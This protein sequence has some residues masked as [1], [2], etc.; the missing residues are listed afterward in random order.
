MTAPRAGR[1]RNAGTK[2]PMRQ[3]LLARQTI[4]R[5]PEN[6]GELFDLA[7]FAQPADLPPEVPA[8]ALAVLVEWHEH[9]DA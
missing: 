3:R 6:R 9:P 7:F 2:Q 4:E 1:R 8:L 5:T